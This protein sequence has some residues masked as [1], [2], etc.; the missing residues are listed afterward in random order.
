MLQAA[1]PGR[2]TSQ[3]S[4]GYSSLEWFFTP[5]Q[6]RLRSAGLVVATTILRPQLAVCMSRSGDR[7]SRPLA[8]QAVLERLWHGF[9]DLGVLEQHVIDNSDQEAETTA[10][11]VMARLA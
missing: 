4:R 9:E 6:D 10:E 8:D 5:L 1:L 3:L 11:I 7:A 2:A